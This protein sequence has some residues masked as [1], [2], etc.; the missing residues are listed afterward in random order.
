GG[1]TTDKPV[2]LVYVGIAGPG[3]TSVK[4]LRH[5]GDRNQIRIRSVKSALSLLLESI[6]N[7]K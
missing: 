3:G 4:E 6:E 7:S 5:R 1:G 2:G